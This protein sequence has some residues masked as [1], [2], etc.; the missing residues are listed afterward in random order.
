MS[1]PAQTFNPRA[2]PNLNALWASLAFEE[3]RRLGVAVVVVAPGSRSAPL[4]MAV[5]GLAGVET[6][7][8][9]D[10][11]AA[12]FVALGAARATGRPGVV[13]T[14][15]GTAVANL[16]PA[17]VEAA[18]T[19]TPLL[20]VTADR[21]PELHDCGANQA[22]RQHD[23]FGTHATWTTQVPCADQRIPLS[24]VL[25]TADEAWHRAVGIGS[26]AG[27]VHLN[28]SFREPLAP[29]AAPWE[30]TLLAPLEGWMESSDPW[31]RTVRA[32]VSLPEALSQ[33]AATLRGESGPPRRGIAVVGACHSPEER[34]IIAAILRRCDGPILADI[35]SSLRHHTDLPRIIAH[36]DLLTRLG[37]CK[38]LQPDFILRLGGNVSSRAIGE[39]LRRAT[40]LGAMQVLVRTGPT[41]HDPDHTA[42]CDVNIDPRVVAVADPAALAECEPLHFSEATF[43]EA[44]LSADRA[45]SE[46]IQ[47]TIG[48]DQGP[49]D[50]P[51]VARVVA[52]GILRSETLVIGNSMAIRDAD[53]HIS[54]GML[55][56]NVAVNRGASGI[57]GLVATAVGHARATKR[58]TH[59]LLGDLSL[60]HDLGS[61]ALVAHS[62]TPIIIVVVNN[63]GGG[64]FHFLPLGRC[65]G[66]LDPWSTAPHG[67]HFKGA[68]EMFGLRFESLGEGSMRGDLM[69]A[70]SDARAS[71]RSAIIEVRTERVANVERHRSIQRRVERALTAHLCTPQAR[72]TA[73]SGS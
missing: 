24:H 65:E 66:A 15:S 63:D 61:L 46:A 10:E 6:V 28:W 13:V 2:A 25:S 21:P 39:F 30:Q 9:H 31:A 37:A 54:T 64:I 41:R 19:G 55:R 33:V 4:A 68:A 71:G 58:P 42:T 23:L 12:G 56:G 48:L 53:M 7:I 62:P 16:L 27:P 70:L 22:I 35:G 17:A 72:V 36:G 26:A 5:A 44:W 51:S 73:E 52:D 49:I 57:D 18:Q 8:A 34:A 60:L 1:D 40:S 11:R 59:L 29:I 47:E 38:G 67:F 32:E 45:A 69:R 43:S 50:E 20:L 14:T 3:W